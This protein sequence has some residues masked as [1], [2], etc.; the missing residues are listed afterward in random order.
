MIAQADTLASTRPEARIGLVVHGARQRLQQMEGWAAI[1]WARRLSIHFAGD[2]TLDQAI[3]ELRSLQ[4]D[5]VFLWAYAA[6][7]G[8]S[9]GDTRLADLADAAGAPVIVPAI[10]ASMAARNF[11]SPPLTGAG[12][13]H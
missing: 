4:P 2:G 6:G 13:L 3:E 7:L 11:L 9:D 5:L 8:P 12:H 10:A 1:P